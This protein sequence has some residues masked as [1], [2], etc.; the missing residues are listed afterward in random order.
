MR[1]IS[2]NDFDEYSYED[3]INY[4]AEKLVPSGGS[5]NFTQGISRFSVNLDELKQ[6][7]KIFEQIRADEE[8]HEKSFS[9]I[10]DMVCDKGAKAVMLAGPSSSGKT[11]SAYRLATQ[12]RIRG[13]KPILL[14]LDD[15]YIDRD[16]IS[17]G[18]DGKM[19]FEH[20]NTIDIALFRENIQQL[21]S[22]KDVILPS[23]NFKNGN[24]QW[25]PV[26]VQMTEDTVF[27][28]EGLHALNPVLLPD[29][30]DG[31]PILRLYVCPLLH[32]HIDDDNHISGSF[33]RL[34][35]RIVRDYK[36][37]GA[38]VQQTIAM[39][40][41]VRR[42]EKS[43]IIPFQKNAD[44]IFNSATLYELTVLKK[45]IIPIL[46][47]VPPQDECYQQIRELATVLNYIP[48]ADIEDEIPLTSIVREF[49]G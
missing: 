44:V 4:C 13:K 41:S 45:H 17:P 3:L 16:K 6:N 1:L 42:G 28:I 34:V 15:Y 11:T 33:L 26:P 5:L 31:S 39:W 10:A 8:L 29:N 37:R 21:L 36:N 27:I 7:G 20:I 2:D 30:L 35:R 40:D 48:D 25:Q 18:P 32:I 22:G 24:R 49:I 43:W 9:Q 38:S 46:N 47:A 19:D 14:G 23:F 12:L